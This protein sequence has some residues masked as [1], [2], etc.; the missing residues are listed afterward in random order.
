MQ[1]ENQHLGVYKRLRVDG[2]Y[3][4]CFFK[5][6]SKMLHNA[7]FNAIGIDKQEYE[8]LRTKDTSKEAP[9]KR[10]VTDWQQYYKSIINEYNL[11]IQNI[12]VTVNADDDVLIDPIDVPGPSNI[13]SSKPD[14]QTSNQIIETSNVAEVE[15]QENEF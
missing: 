3:T 7:L 9:I 11:Y 15:D 12:P 13:T 4:E 2:R 1:N 14:V 8:K 5:A 10:V 6:P